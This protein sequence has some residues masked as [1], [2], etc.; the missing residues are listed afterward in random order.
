MVLQMRQ[1]TMHNH[2]P[3]DTENTAELSNRVSTGQSRFPTKKFGLNFSQQCLADNVLLFK[4]EFHTKPS[5]QNPFKQNS[6]PFY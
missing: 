6:R 4:A 3:N 5:Q 2:L 1:A